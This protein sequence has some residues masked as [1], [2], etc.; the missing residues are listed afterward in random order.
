[1]QPIRLGLVGYGKIAQDQHVPA[2]KANPAF[3]LVSVATQG[4]P[5]AGVENF[6]SLGELLE[7]GPPVDA[8]A[9]CTP[10]QGRFALVQQA[11]AVL[12]PAQFLDR[13]LRH[14]AVAADLQVEG[15]AKGGNVL[16]AAFRYLVRLALA[17]CARHP[18]RP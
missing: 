3:Q 9:F 10:P 6:K 2:I 1:M 16:V 18:G 5:C 8:I 4:Q 17:V 7:N 12:E 14:M 13:A 11:L 15:A